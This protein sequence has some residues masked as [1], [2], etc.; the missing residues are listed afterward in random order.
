MLS[1]R[2]ILNVV[3]QEIQQSAGGNENDFI[4][5]NRQKALATYLGQPDGNE[6][7][8][9][10]SV[11]ST[12]VADTIEW[13]MP[14]IVKAFTQNNEVVTFDAVN[15]GDEQQAELESQYVYDILMKD[16]TGFLI[17]HQ[18]IKDALMQKNGFIKVFYDESVSETTE[19]YTGLT[20][21]ELNMVLSDDNIELIEMSTE[22]IDNIPIF[23]IK[24][25]VVKVNKKIKVISVPPEEF[26]IN[27]LHNS[28]DVSDARFTAH[29]V[30]KSRTDLINEGY[31][32]ELVYSLN[33]A[34]VYEDDREYRFYMQDETVYPDRDVSSDRSLDLIEISECYM[35]LDVDETGVAKLMKV[36][37]SGGDNPDQL[38]DI[39]EIDSNPFISATAILMSHK[40]FGLSI[41]DRIKQI[42]EQKTA[43][44][45]NILDNMY[46]Q[47]NQ[48]TIAIDGQVNLDD[49]MVSRPG[50]IIRVKTAN[51]VTPYVTPPLNSDAYKM[52]DYLDQVRASRAGVSPEGAVTDNM[53]GDRVGS[54]GVEKMMNQKEELV[55][56]MV[57]VIA[58]TGI[59]PLCTMIRNE[60]IKH[61]D[62]IKEY[63]FRGNWVQVNPSKW[64]DRPNTT[65]RVG[66]GS[67]NRKEQVVALSNIAMAQEKLLQTPGQVLVKPKHVYAVIDDLAKTSGL[68]GAS[69]YLL[70]PE[71]PEGKENQKKADE[72][73]KAKQQK[74]MQQEQAMMQMQSK[75]A[76]AEVEKAKANS[77]NVQLKAQSDQQKNQI[78]IMKEQANAEIAML[79]QQLSE[80]EAIAN[81][82]NKSEDLDF[83]YYDAN[84]RASIERERIAMQDKQKAD[85]ESEKEVTDE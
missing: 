4:D 69:K 1:E 61:Q 10:S 79:K 30:L 49:L 3:A 56:L 39:E 16:N 42:Q 62:V 7:E 2:Q 38:L 59:K 82:S 5:A 20:E 41:Y 77:A 29:V 81:D 58:E 72:A 73:S 76:D 37:T 26:R 60:A 34:E 6:V 44:W 31:D 47:N 64:S 84:Q 25:K 83:K 51:A 28:V 9:R 22:E 43:L 8:G 54:E 18:F 35:H 17:L 53:I 68:T 63:K 32:K 27:K 46:L 75:L 33:T 12:D 13:I 70:D 23:D 50:G 11:I 66:T 40:L 36:S 52:M 19:S 74:D 14:E 57:R 65:V 71:S 85:V 21:P 67:G 78:T 80:A 48:R 24:V 55:G 15:E 45:R